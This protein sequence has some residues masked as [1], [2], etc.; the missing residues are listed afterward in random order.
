M[1]SANIIERLKNEVDNLQ[2]FTKIKID[3]DDIRFDFI[4]IEFFIVGFATQLIEGKTIHLN[5]FEKQR[6]STPF[7]I[8]EKWYGYEINGFDLASYPTLKKYAICLEEIRSLILKAMN[9]Y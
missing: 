3:D 8:K 5:S 4:S 7:I 9:G 1:V 2:L 6:I